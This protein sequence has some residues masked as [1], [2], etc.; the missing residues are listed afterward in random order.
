MRTPVHTWQLVCPEL[1]R[2][3]SQRSR[4][5]TRRSTVS[6]HSTSRFGEGRSL[7]GAH[8]VQ[9]IWWLTF[10]IVGLLALTIVLVA[11]LTP[12][13][14]AVARELLATAVPV[15]LVVLGTLVAR[16]AL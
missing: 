14:G 1:I 13:N 10:A 9:A 3:F 16:L 15:E 11:V 8:E 5:T 2:A 12:V 6:L 4:R 7:E